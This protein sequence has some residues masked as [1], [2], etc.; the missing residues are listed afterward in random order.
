LD[1]HAPVRVETYLRRAART[2]AA[3]AAGIIMTRR[4]RGVL[5]PGRVVSFAAAWLG[6]CRGATVVDGGESGG[7][8]GG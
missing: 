2:A 8:G 7:E 4:N 6:G 5:I 1:I 3:A